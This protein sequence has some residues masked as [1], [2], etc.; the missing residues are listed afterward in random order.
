MG[1]SRSRRGADGFCRGDARPSAH[2]GIRLSQGRVERSRGP[3]V[4]GLSR[5]REV[6]VDRPL[7][8]AIPNKCGFAAILNIEQSTAR[9]TSRFA[10]RS[11]YRST[12]PEEF[13]WPI[14]FRRQTFVHWTIER[15]LFER[16][17]L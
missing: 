1:K 10:E 6:K 7:R 9:S 14:D 17:A 13:C 15:G 16:F 5:Q 8:R 4:R 11:V 3:K 12:F 2:R